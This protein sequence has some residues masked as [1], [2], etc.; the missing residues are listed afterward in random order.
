MRWVLSTPTHT[1]THTHTHTPGVQESDILVYMYMYDT[2]LLWFWVCVNLFFF[3]NEAH[4][5][6]LLAAACAVGVSCNFAAPIGGLALSP[7]LYLCLSP[8]L[9][10]PSLPPSCILFFSHLFRCIV[11]HWS[12]VHLLCCEEL[13]AWVLRSCVWGFSLSTGGR[14]L[15]RWRDYHCSL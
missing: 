2:L 14:P 12:N 13:L 10:S 15:S 5:N 4:S 3:Q 9:S 7:S 8:S 6:E 1:H 11:Q